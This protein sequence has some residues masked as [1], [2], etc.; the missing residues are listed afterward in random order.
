MRYL[1]SIILL[2]LLNKTAGSQPND[3]YF[4]R[5]LTKEDGLIH[6]N[7]FDISQDKKGFIWIATGNG[8]Q[9]YDGYRFHNYRD[10]LNDPSVSYPRAG[11]ICEDGSQNVFW[12]NKGNITEKVEPESG[13]ITYY[14]P[15]EIRKQ[16]EFAATSYRGANGINCFLNPKAIFYQLPG[17]GGV[18]MLFGNQRA[19]NH[20]SG[21]F[22][23][24]RATGETWQAGS[25][26]GISLFDPVTKRIYSA[27]DDTLRHPLLKA[28][29]RKFGKK[30]FSARELMLDSHNN[31]WI[32][33]WGNSFF[34]YDAATR[35]LT[36]YSLPKF[37][38]VSCFY[39]DDHQVIW[40]GTERAGLLRYDPAA[41]GFRAV[42]AD[43]ADKVNNLMDYNF[44]RIVQDREQ[45]IWLASD[46]GIV[47]FNPYR[48]FFRSIHHDESNKASLPKYEVDG[49]IQT[50]NGEILVG[51]WGGGITVYDSAWTFKRNIPLHGPPEYNFVWCF[52]Q[53][54]DGAI[55]AGCQH[56]YLHI[57]DPVSGIVK[58]L[59]PPETDNFT[60]RCMAKDHAGNI[61]MGLHNGKIVEWNKGERKFVGYN[62]SYPEKDRDF[63]SV[64]FIFFDGKGRCWVSTEKGLK[65]FD[66]VSRRYVAE[67]LP[68]TRR[69]GQITALAPKGIAQWNDSTLLIGTLYGGMDLF[70]PESGVFEPVPIRDSLLYNNIF[71]VKKD[72]AGYCWFTTDYGLC[73]FK[74][75][76]GKIT[77]YN[78]GTGMINSA[79][80]AVQFDTLKN[81]D[82]VTSTATSIVVFHPSTPQIKD[83]ATIEITGCKIFD[84]IVPPGSLTAA[85][86]LRLA[87]NKNFITIEFARLRF[88]D[89]HQNNYYYRLKGVNDEWI[90]AGTRAFATYT[91]LPP[92]SYQ[93]EVKADDGDG[94]G[95]TPATSFEI[96]VTPPFWKTWW[97]LS[98]AA[99]TV[100]YVLYRLIS[101]RIE[102]LRI[103]EKLSLAKLE[104]LR[105]QMN[106][107][108]IFNCL[109]SIDN[110]I[111]TGDK[112]KATT[113]LA[114]FARLIR[115][116]LETSKVNSIPCWKDMET[117]ALYLEMEALRCDRIFSYKLEIAD[118]ITSGDYRVPPLVIQPFVENAIHH[119]LL[120]KREK[121][122]Q[123][124]ITV[125]ASKEY[126]HYTIEDNGVGREKAM[127]YR[128]LNKPAHQSMGLQITTDRIRLFNKN[129]ATAVIITDLYDD[130]GR[131]AGTKVQVNLINQ[132]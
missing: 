39:E 31:L 85:K 14:S 71:A 92:G 93:F 95:M 78:I 15:G 122:K 29:R 110:L 89:L 1:R 44:N 13:K 80:N 81:G 9:R 108:F 50:R 66:P 116:I 82:W 97:F 77:R 99:I 125:T 19:T 114:K 120:N 8:L 4:F 17:I 7:V 129:G 12:I 109:S 30:Q 111:Q 22:S 76:D 70:N 123:L 40:V 54:D 90:N 45:N 88:S 103:N 131:A 23:T 21:F 69:P 119:G 10:V 42:L 63:P 16:P 105:S 64:N 68:D 115:S 117:L 128:R 37:R 2:L 127:E 61:W 32:S 132:P 36:R 43:D 33:S 41:D 96:V 124:L 106:P 52:M 65:K 62:D 79:F 130:A 113:Y 53:N 58:T 74:L 18:S 24:N 38:G 100:A 35:R 87:H 51:S 27:L 86:P 98:L 48:Q 75:K 34:K 102:V 56:G 28:L 59:R 3:R 84:S 5:H 20:W 126:I 94:G 49:M 121:D 73:R 47:I 55:W 101:W 57:Y 112:G 60:I 26:K 67:Y 6:N 11:I 91:N 25:V 83:P 46:K 107:H 72:A 118:E 104:A